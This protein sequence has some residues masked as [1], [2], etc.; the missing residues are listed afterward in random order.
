MAPFLAFVLKNVV[1][2]PSMFQPLW[3]IKS[4]QKSLVALKT[5]NRNA[6][7]HFLPTPITY[8]SEMRL[9]TE[10]K[11]LFKEERYDWWSSSFVWLPEPPLLTWT[12]TSDKTRPMR[13][14]L[15]R[16]FMSEMQQQTQESTATRHFRQRNKMIKHHL[17]QA[18]WQFLFKFRTTT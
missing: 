7:V 17:T 6:P 16:R 3:E 8:K 9:N 13:F 14:I 15:S 4:S 5:T 11:L 18:I 10:G 1:L 2:I 12:W